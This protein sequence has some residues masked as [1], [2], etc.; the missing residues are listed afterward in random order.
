MYAQDGFSEQ[1]QKDTVSRVVI[2]SDHGGFI[3]KEVLKNTWK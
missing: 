1:N 3:A 2:G